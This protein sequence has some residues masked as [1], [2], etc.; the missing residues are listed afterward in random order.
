MALKG[1]HPLLDACIAFL[2]DNPAARQEAN[3]SLERRPPGQTWVIPVASARTWARAKAVLDE[4]TLTGFDDLLSPRV[5]VI[6]DFPKRRMTSIGLA[7]TAIRYR[8]E[9]AL[10]RSEALLQRAGYQMTQ[11]TAG[12]FEYRLQS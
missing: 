12:V 3:R 5:K 4:K 6:I 1:E 9:A 11:D 10:K 8:N 7:G 2:V